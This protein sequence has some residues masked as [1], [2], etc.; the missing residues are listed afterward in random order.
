[1]LMREVVVSLGR[2]CALVG[3]ESVV[4]VALCDGGG[5]HGVGEGACGGR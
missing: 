5:G 3:E 1:M 4:V 2:V